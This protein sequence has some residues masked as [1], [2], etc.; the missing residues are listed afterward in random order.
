M[1]EGRDLFKINLRVQGVPQSAGLEDQGRLTKI[2][3]LV[4]TLRTEYRTES[5]IADLS[6]TREFNRFSEAFKKTAKIGKD[7]IV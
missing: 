2:R 4:K 1:C 3:D 7:L 6:K 5:V